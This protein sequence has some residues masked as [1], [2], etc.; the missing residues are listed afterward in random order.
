L[1]PV[2]KLE[3]V[4]KS[5]K[6]IQNMEKPSLKERII[7]NSFWSFGAITL[8]RLG[9][10][11][12]TI[13][14]ARF[15]MPEGFGL[16]SIILSTAMIFFTFADLGINQT[17][18]RYIS[19]ALKKEKKKIYSYH[20]YL[21]RLKFIVA[22]SASLIFIALAYP[23]AFYVF[24]KPI[25]FLPF[26]IAAFY[27]F[28]MS[29]ETFYS[30]LFYSI[31][32]VKY[33]SLKESLNSILRIVFAFI[34]FHFIAASYQLIGIFLSFSIISIFL[35]LFSLFY[36]K[37]LL[38]EIYT[39]TDAGINKKQ[40]RR[41][42]FFLT[43]A[44]ISS[45]F[46][47]YIDTIMLGIFVSPEFVGYYR[48]AFAFVFGIIG[49]MSFANVILLP[50]FTKLDSK[51]TNQ[52]LEKAFKYISLITIPT[53]FGLLALGKYF[54]KIFFGSEYLPASLPFY[55]LSIL[56]FP[57]VSVGLFLAFFSAEERPEI[58]AKLIII[59]NVVNIFLNL[60]LIRSLLFI[61]QAWA[62]AGAAI[63]TTLS[64]SLYLIL[65]VYTIKKEFNFLIS[66]KPVIKPL[67]AS[68]IM[69]EILFYVVNSIQDMNLFLG[70]N[71]IFLGMF[72]Y[73]L[74]M[75]LM[76]G[77]GKKDFELVKILFKRK[78]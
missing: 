23:L 57:V 40:V 34:I 8:N 53:I 67:I 45:V 16:Y 19:S 32:K 52:V 56:I 60:I 47:S 25:L 29:F 46:F 59:V 54:I 11:I 20:K 9:G 12:L 39:K 22:L 14:L 77:L 13:I 28:V 42:A 21:L 76:K 71:I 3:K 17:L 36:L 31:E 49:V 1:N 37:K 26:L 35:I 65:S 5:L 27:I 7:L 24:E 58:F 6:I 18:V 44:S 41:F 2:G 72:S 30:D 38:P 62:I 61:S 63:A 69:F 68:I 51:K 10:L 15:L 48:V 4:Y 78:A 70:I 66:F 50:I 74:A 33:L 64:W 55:F 75:I 43:I 73:V